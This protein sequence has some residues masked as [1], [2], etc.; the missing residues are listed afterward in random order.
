M[1]PETHQ[2]AVLGIF[3]ESKPNTSL[4]EN[5]TIAEWRKYFSEAGNLTRITDSTVI[6]LNLALL[7][8][9][10]LNDFWRYEGSLTTPPCTEGI[11]WTIFKTP[12]LF[13]ES[14][15]ESFRENILFED[16][17]GPQPLYDRLIYRNFLTETLSSVPDYNCCLKALY[18]RGNHCSYLSLSYFLILCFYLI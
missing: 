18:N 13:T 1:N 14:E 10:N 8:G 11:I 15:I 5:L 7:M 6:S 16:Y 17:R 12:I 3:M 4:N 2:I 9:T